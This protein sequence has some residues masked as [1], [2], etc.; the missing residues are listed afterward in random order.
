MPRRLRVAHSMNSMT[1]GSPSPAFPKKPFHCQNEHPHRSLA[2][3]S[4]SA[5]LDRWTGKLFVRVRRFQQSCRDFLDRDC[6]IPI[7]ALRV[8]QC[9][10][11]DYLTVFIHHRGTTRTLRN[12]AV[13]WM[14]ERFSR[15]AEMMPSETLPVRSLD[16][17]DS[18]S[19]TPFTFG[20]VD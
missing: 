3:A 10:N 11:A 1:T 8:F 5:V 7:L 16:Q 6:Q 19:N 2:L 20:L 14:R 18:R 13:I 15:K 9:G 17:S 4:L 12:V